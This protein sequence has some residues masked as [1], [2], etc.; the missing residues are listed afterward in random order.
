MAIYRL[1][2][3]LLYIR[4]LGDQNGKIWVYKSDKSSNNNRNLIYN[5][6]NNTIAYY[7]DI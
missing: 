3:K 4:K 2:Q 7:L 6:K 1:G 5:V